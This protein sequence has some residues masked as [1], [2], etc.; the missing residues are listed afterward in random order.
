MSDLMVDQGVGVSQEV[1]LLQLMKYKER[2]AKAEEEANALR[3][4]VEHEQEI[5]AAA[6]AKGR[7]RRK[8]V[9]EPDANDYAEFKS[10]GVRKPSPADSIRSYDDFV[11][12]QNYFL[13]KG[14]VRDYALWT[15]GVGTG[16]RV[17][18]LISL[19]FRNVL[20]AGRTFRE[21]IKV[22]ERK[23]GKLN[24]VLLT[25]AV[26]A[27]FSRYFDSIGWVFDEDD[28]IFSSQKGRGKNPMAPQ[29][30]WHL[31]STAGKE[32]GLPLNFGSHTMRKSFANIVACADKGTVD[33]NVITKV[34]GLL[35]HSDQRV[36][37]R[38]LGTFEE[39]Y[40][41]ARQTVSNFILGKSGVNVLVASERHTMEDLYER[42]EA[43]ERALR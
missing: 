29:Y 25:E 12:V 5:S 3:S 33:M 30:A 42:L 2:A 28:F 37:M 27:A 31:I 24:N 40:D 18:D 8:R 7:R 34:Q 21:R 20:E 23:T 22:F 14:D 35:N 15:V 16:L 32:I 13:K 36:T 9:V 39:M 17:S 10:D 6:I 11:A 41:R 19:Q 43:L 1:L 38:Y 26:T 4:I